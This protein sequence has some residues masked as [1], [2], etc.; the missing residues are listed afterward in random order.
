M[1]KYS[2]RKIQNKLKTY[3]IIYE[4]NLEKTVFRTIYTQIQHEHNMN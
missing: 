4:I 3:G 1:T 2:K